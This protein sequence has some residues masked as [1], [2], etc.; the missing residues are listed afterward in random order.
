MQ[1]A[2]RDDSTHAAIWESID[3]SEILGNRDTGK[4]RG[5]YHKGLHLEEVVRA[6][7]GVDGEVLGW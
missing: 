6:V 3:G 1:R 2:A 5:G 7:E 4:E